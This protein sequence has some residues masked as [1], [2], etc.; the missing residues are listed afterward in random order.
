MDKMAIKIN[1][2]KKS[3]FN[4]EKYLDTITKIID[5][6]SL[7]KIADESLSDFV[8]AS[9]TTE[10]A[11]GWE[12][13][14]ISNKNKVSL[15]FNNKVVEN[16]QNIAIIID[17]GHGTTDGRWISGKNYLKEPIRKTY[18]RIINKTREALNKI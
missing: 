9:P 11:L 15:F 4:S 14:I 7:K 6:E 13:E 1:V 17:V 18:E 3:R 16:G 12:Y 2:K 8:R 5:I 10:I